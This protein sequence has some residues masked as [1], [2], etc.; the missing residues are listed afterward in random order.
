MDQISTT[1]L[2]YNFSIRL[3]TQKYSND[4]EFFAQEDW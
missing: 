1:K 4:S 3:T 2:L